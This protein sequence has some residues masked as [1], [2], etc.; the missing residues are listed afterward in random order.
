GQSVTLNGSG[1]DPQGG[2]LSYAWDLDGDLIYETP[3]Q[4]P[5]FSAAGLPGGTIRTV[6]VRVSEGNGSY[7][8][9]S[10]AVTVTGAARLAFVV[11]PGG[12][13]VGAPLSPPPSVLAQ[14]ANGNPVSSFSGPVTLSLGNNP[15]GGMLNGTLTVS[16]VNG[17]A[18]FSDLS[19]SAAG[20]GYTLVATSGALQQTSSAPFTISPRPPPT[21]TP[22]SCAPRPRV[23]VQV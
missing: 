14:D 7:A 9:A 21:L 4:S 23:D 5:A 3:G 18:T 15:G 1:V 2:T 12:A 16:A 17:V 19:I 6:R 22:A 10:T 11:Q 8:L 20:S 13:Q